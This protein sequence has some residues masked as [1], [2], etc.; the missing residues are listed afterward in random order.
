M[1]QPGF[2]FRGSLGGFA[3]SPGYSRSNVVLVPATSLFRIG[4]PPSHWKHLRLVRARDA[5]LDRLHFPAKNAGA[6]WLPG[7]ARRTERFGLQP[8]SPFCHSG[9]VSH[10]TN[11]TSFTTCITT[12]ATIYRMST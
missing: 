9:T 1:F 2:Q 7:T 8:P 6:S 4:Y 5:Y 12:M 11:G 10:Q 3:C